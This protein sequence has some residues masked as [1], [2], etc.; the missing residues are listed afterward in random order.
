MPW[1]TTPRIFRGEEAS[2][3]GHFKTDDLFGE[4]CSAIPLTTVRSS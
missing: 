3:V 2:K 4:K 1:E